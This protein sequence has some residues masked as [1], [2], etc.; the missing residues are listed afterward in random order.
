MKHPDQPMQ[1]DDRGIVRFKSNKLIKYLVD[2]KII[3]LNMCCVLYRS[4]VAGITIE[5]YAQLMQLIG[6]SVDGFCSLDCGQPRVDDL[7]PMAVTLMAAQDVDGVRKGPHDERQNAE[8][9]S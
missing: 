7:W 9:K 5:D 6:Y 2:N 4:K 1:I 8:K 3:D